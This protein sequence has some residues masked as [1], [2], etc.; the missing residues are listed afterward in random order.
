MAKHVARWRAF[1]NHQT[2]ER[3]G[4]PRPGKTLTFR[5]AANKMFEHPAE[6]GDRGNKGPRNLESILNIHVY[7]YIGDAEIGEIISRDIM[8]CLEPIWFEKRVTAKKALQGIRAVMRWAI[9]HGYRE[10]DPTEFVRDG[11]G[12]NPARTVHMPSQHHSLIGDALE[13]IEGSKAYW[14]TKAAILFL[15][16][17]ATRGVTVREARW[18]EIDLVGAVWT[19]P[20]SRAKGREAFKV[21]LS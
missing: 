12:P 8:A 18:D 16:L 11:L 21:P 17:T 19:I 5:E 14:I 13:I 2:I 3:G 15:A 6:G 10:S 1:K 7:P 4:D 20:A 9:A